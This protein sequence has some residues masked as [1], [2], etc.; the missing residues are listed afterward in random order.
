LRSSEALLT[1]YSAVNA[2]NV[3]AD[4]NTGVPLDKHISFRIGTFTGMLT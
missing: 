4:A 3:L 2:Q 1:P